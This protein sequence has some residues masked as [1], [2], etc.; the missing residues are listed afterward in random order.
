MNFFPSRFVIDKVSELLNNPKT[1]LSDIV[2]APNVTKSI[3]NKQMNLIDFLNNHWKELI[4][5]S[6]NL[7]NT[8]TPQEQ[9]Y[10]DVVLR[11]YASKFSIKCCKDDYFMQKFEEKFN[12]PAVSERTLICLGETYL[13]IIKTEENEALEILGNNPEFYTSL[14][15]KLQYNSIFEI[16]R[17]ITIQDS[18]TVSTFFD[19]IEISKLLYKFIQE[20]KS[21]RA[22]VLLGLVCNITQNS[23]PDYLQYISKKKRLNYLLTLSLETTDLNLAN[24]LFKFF[25]SLLNQIDFAESSSLDSTSS[26]YDECIPQLLDFF[27]SKYDSLAQYSMSNKPFTECKGS[28]IHITARILPLL[29][30][31]SDATTHLLDYLFELT[32]N[33]PTNS[34]IHNS[35]L[36]F[37]DS[38]KASG[39]SMEDFDKRCQ[40][41]SRIATVFK[42]KNVM[43]ANFWCHLLVVADS[44][45]EVVPEVLADST[46]TGISTSESN[47]SLN[48]S[49]SGRSN[50]NYDMQQNDNFIHSDSDIESSIQIPKPPEDLFCDDDDDVFGEEIDIED[51]A[52]DQL[53]DLFYP[54][55]NI[56][57]LLP[58]V[59]S[60]IRSLP[61]ES[62]NFS[63]QP[64]YFSPSTKKNKV[65][66]KGSLPSFPV[67]K[68]SDVFG[69]S[70][71]IDLDQDEKEDNTKTNCSNS[72]PQIGPPPPI[73]KLP[74]I[75]MSPASSLRA[76][77]LVIPEMPDVNDDPGDPW[78]H[79][80][81]GPFRIMTFI[82]SHEYGGPL[83]REPSDN[84]FDLGSSDEE[85][86]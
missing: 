9:Y 39:I 55:D 63:N 1:T 70:A 49:P 22:V 42:K 37:F 38:C 78:D 15:N 50:N 67:V 73:P 40:V 3:Q 16:V 51:S 33:N 23:I 68:P 28:C 32:L 85:D 12:D 79:F 58:P 64:V 13:S 8:L 46:D 6:L 75:A 30:E 83:P 81:K 54:K 31:S 36:T 43:L 14:L 34:M 76:K 29:K 60:P 11:A 7:S 65:T 35:F 53:T 25:G 71:S 57:T 82:M 72:L 44:F 56:A 19:K 2:H 18:Y 27:D 84:F 47:V 77:T 41:K 80:V 17:L 61:M 26:D 52:P 66:Y 21:T 45:V 86:F 69:S 4:D 5:S 24:Q 20:N 10:Y 59:E 74:V 48:D 62:P